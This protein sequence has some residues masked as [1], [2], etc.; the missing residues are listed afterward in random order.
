[1]ISGVPGLPWDSHA[2][3]FRWHNDFFYNQLHLRMQLHG[4]SIVEGRTRPL[5]EGQE[6]DLHNDYGCTHIDC[7]IAEQGIRQLPTQ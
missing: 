3:L 6:L 2:I 5:R 4:L 1:M 7:R